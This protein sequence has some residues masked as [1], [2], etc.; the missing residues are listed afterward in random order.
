MK[1]AKSQHQRYGP[2]LP[3]PSGTVC[4]KKYPLLRKP[5]HVKNPTFL[6]LPKHRKDQQGRRVDQ[7]TKERAT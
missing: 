1:L 3:L 2:S 4:S 7:K 5:F 6:N